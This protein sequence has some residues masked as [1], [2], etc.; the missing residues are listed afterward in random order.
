MSL[1]TLTCEDVLQVHQL[2]VEE[3]ERSGD[4]ISPAGLKESALLESAVGR[5]HVGFGGKRKYDTPELSAATLTYG[6]CNN[7]AFHNGNK[8]TA[9]VSMLLHL[10]RNGL[11][12]VGTAHDEVL[13]MILAVAEHQM[14]VPKRSKRSGEPSRGEPDEEVAAIA[15]WIRDRKPT[16]GESQIPFRQLRHILKSYGFE[17]EVVSGNEVPR[18]VFN[19]SPPVLLP[20][21]NDFDRKPVPS[22]P[23]WP[24]TLPP[25]SAR[26]YWG[27]VVPVLGSPAFGDYP[28]LH[29]LGI[30]DSISGGNT[31]PRLFVSGFLAWGIRWA[32]DA[33]VDPSFGASPFG[34]GYELG[35][36]PANS[37]YNV[38][39]GTSLLLPS[40]IGGL[41]TKVARIGGRR[42]QGSNPPE[43]NL[44]E[45]VNIH[46]M[47][48][49]WQSGSGTIPSM[50]HRRHFGNV[51]ILPN[52]NLF[53][54]GGQSGP[55]AYN[56][57]PELWN[58]VSWLPMAPHAGARDYHAAAILLPDARVL[59]CGGEARAAMP[60]PGADYLLWEPPYFH[61]DYGSVPPTGIQ[62]RHAVTQVLVP[63]H[64]IGP[65]NNFT[66]GQSYEASWSNE[67][68]D[69]ITVDGVVLVRPAAMTHHDDGGQRLVRLTTF[70]GA[71]GDSAVQ[72]KSPGSS[73]EAPPGWWMLFLVTSS[74]R[75]SQAYWVHLQ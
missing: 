43:S 42:A 11:Q 75:P 22:Q 19:A 13:C 37:D 27:P 25:P 41:S 30:L 34:Q 21:P 10:E 33:A 3:F 26:Q 55:G 56:L 72:F 39:Y 5:Q 1:H 57:I 12:I 14:S 51:V 60:S 36:F 28:R 46:S 7:H 6:I 17:M 9:L 71:D 67:L 31:A 29:A 53:A 16:K 24:G 65:S 63:Q 73:R 69:G 35:Q 48:S 18:I 45:T 47:P 59:V 50:L 62:V 74:G 54:V 23:N 8:R 61:L 64:L 40:P 70:A 49:A 44:V 15:K 58:G 38:D 52:G 32:H 4:R 20:S 2:L 66:Y 68:E